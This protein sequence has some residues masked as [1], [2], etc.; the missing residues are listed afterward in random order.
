MKIRE[1]IALCSGIDEWHT[2][3]FPE[4]NIPSFMMSDGPNGLRKQEGQTDMLGMNQSKPATCFPT[5]SIAACSFDPDLM[6]RYGYEIAREAKMEGV[7]MILGPGITIKRNPLCGRNFEYLSEEPLVSGLLGAAY[8]RG[9]QSTGIGACLKHFACNNQEYYRM[10][11]DSLVDQRTLRE[12]YLLPFEIAIKESSPRAVM[13]AYNKING[14]YCCSSQ[15][16]LTDI[17]RREWKF[18][19]FV[20][21]DWSAAEDRTASFLAGCDLIMPGGNA[22]G[23]ADA[24]ENIREGKLPREHVTRSAK[25]IAKF[26]RKANKAIAQA[27]INEP[28]QHKISHQIAGTIAEESMVLL[29]NDHQILPLENLEDVV[30]I[31][32]MAEQIRYQG[33]GSSRVNPT[34]LEQVTELYPQVLYEPGYDENGETTDILIARARKLAKTAKKVVIF[35]GLP[36]IYESEGYDREHM[37][38]PEGH[39]RLIR[40]VAQVNPNVIV[41]LECGSA[42]EVPWA[43]NV[44]AILY[45]GLSGQ[46]GAGAIMRILTGEVNPSGKLAE[47]WPMKYED[48]V[49]ASYYG[50]GHRNAQYREGIYVG[51]RYYEKAK[52]PVRFPFGYG[53]SYTTFAYSNPKLDRST[54]ILSVTVTNTGDRAGKEVVFMFVRNFFKECYRP[55]RIMKHFAKIELDPGESQVVQIELDERDFAIWDHGWIVDE[56]TYELQVTGNPLSEGVSLKVEADQDMLDRSNH[57]NLSRIRQQADAVR[58]YAEYT[59]QKERFGPISDWYRN[60]VGPPSEADFESIYRWPLPKETKR[61]K[62][63]DINSN[64][65]D[66]VKDSLILRMM[67]K[68]FEETQAR[69]N[70]RDSADYKGMMIMANEVPLRAV[71]NSLKLKKHTA[72]AFADMGNKHYISM[73]KHLLS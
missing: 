32:Q 15:R 73:V 42:V 69:E 24:L 36:G 26:A 2:K 16:L 54:K 48:V 61:K 9:V 59:Q 44:R 4:E 62:P 6:E 47:T 46:A 25:R 30:F 38:M 37:K 22:F 40:E 7:G 23:E 13:A 64:I 67:Y 39:N 50:K 66:V 8:V 53:L 56:G 17:L 58:T 12:I 33:Y 31:G 20:V 55:V 28:M 45:A 10:T 65:G 68:K 52:I 51:Y 60:P 35:A 11:S 71:Q 19:G 43:D 5:A 63:Y 29:K 70:G 34:K 57:G 27:R 41:V 1:Q 3:E 72:Q 49:S 21:S 18:N 14:T